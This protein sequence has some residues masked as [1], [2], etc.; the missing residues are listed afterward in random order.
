MSV[1]RVGNK[2]SNNL[3]P[4]VSPT[5]NLDFANSKTLDPRITF[6][7][8]SGGSYVDKNGVIKYAGVNE[9]RFDHDPV[10]GRSKGLLIEEQRIN[11]F[12][13]SRW[14]SDIFP[15]PAP[16]GSA[17]G[18]FMFLGLDWIAATPDNDITFEKNTVYTTSMWVYHEE[19]TPKNFFQNFPNDT[20]TDQIFFYMP[21]SFVISTKNGIVPPRTWQRYSVTFNTGPFPENLPT[22][23]VRSFQNRIPT[24]GFAYYA[25]GRQ[26][27]KGSSPSSY[28]PTSGSTRTRAADRVQLIGNNFSSWYNTEESTILTNFYNENMSSTPNFDFYLSTLSNSQSPL[29]RASSRIAVVSGVTKGLLRSFINNGTTSEY[30]I[31]NGVYSSGLGRA[32]MSY[33]LQNDFATTFNGLPVQIDDS[34]RV[35]NLNFDRLSIGS[36]A[37]A[38]G[39]FLNGHISRLVYWPKRLTNEQLKTLTL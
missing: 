36:N 16:D 10:S 21:G 25:F 38:N 29:K 18:K 7:R 33:K 9:P 37:D 13:F 19:S 3:F 34:G 15:V 4:I 2:S 20:S 22:V 12:R 35:S 14:G 5:L 30:A 28:I 11:L 6:T 39:E 31:D 24:P 1:Y 26:I 8:S 23:T 32:I 17:T 27:E